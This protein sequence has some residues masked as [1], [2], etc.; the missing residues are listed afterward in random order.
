[1]GDRVR[2]GAISILEIYASERSG[3]LRAVEVDTAASRGS[4]RLARDALSAV[5]VALNECRCWRYHGG[6]CT[7]QYVLHSD[8][9]LDAAALLRD[10]WNPGEPLRRLR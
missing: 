7:C 6:S 1:M 5:H 10:G 8:C 4:C 3:S 2:K 9:A